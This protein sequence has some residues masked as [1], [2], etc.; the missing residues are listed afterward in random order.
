ML[1]CDIEISTLELDHSCSCIGYS[2]Y[3][4]RKPKFNL[5]KA[6]R[7]NVPKFYGVGFRRGNLVYEGINI[8]LVWLWE[9]P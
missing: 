7:N 3:I 8:I 9:K 1:S 6:E 4:N 2:L 5:E